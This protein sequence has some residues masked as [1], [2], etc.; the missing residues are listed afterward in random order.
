MLTRIDLGGRVFVHASDIQLL[1]AATVDRIL[2]WA[3]HWVLA[4]GP[5]LYLGGLDAGQRARARAGPTSGV[6]PQGLAL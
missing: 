1:D 6:W 4:V 2:D 3:P 5:P